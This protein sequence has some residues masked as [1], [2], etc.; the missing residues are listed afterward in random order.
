MK[1]IPERSLC[2]KSGISG[3]FGGTRSSGQGFYPGQSAYDKRR[4]PY[5][6][7]FQAETQK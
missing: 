2:G 4:D 1:E 6:V 3:A 5:S 7:S